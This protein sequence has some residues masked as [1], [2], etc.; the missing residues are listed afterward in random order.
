MNPG[1]IG[2][3]E[4]IGLSRIRQDH[5]PK[6]A[7]MLCCFNKPDVFFSGKAHLAD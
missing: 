7:P 6:C 4:T 2:M 5:A 1:V 3:V